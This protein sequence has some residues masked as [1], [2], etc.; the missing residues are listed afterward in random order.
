MSSKPM[1]NIIAINMMD[2]IDIHNSLCP[3]LHGFRSK[4]S[5]EHQRISFTKDIAFTL[6]STN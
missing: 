6:R 4:D 2:N 5:C 3:Q 1:E